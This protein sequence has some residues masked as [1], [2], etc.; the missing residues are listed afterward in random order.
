VNAYI[1]PFKTAIQK[2]KDLDRA[3]TLAQKAVNQFPNEA[4]SH[5][6]LAELYLLKGELALAN[7]A[8][9]TAFTF[10]PNLAETHLI[11]GK[12]REAQSNHEGAKWEYKKAFE[13]S[14]SGD[15]INQEAATRYNLLM[16]LAK[17]LQ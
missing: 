8:L 9:Q 11:A 14:R 17:P 3:L 5:R 10:D 13:L 15:E 16:N 12:I 1:D 7:D 6:F 2:V 4:M